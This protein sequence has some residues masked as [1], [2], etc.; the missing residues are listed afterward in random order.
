MDGKNTWKICSFPTFIF[1][2]SSSLV[3]IHAHSFISFA[4]ANPR[5]FREAS[6]LPQD[7]FGNNLPKRLPRIWLTWFL[8]CLFLFFFPRTLLS[9]DVIDAAYNLRI[10]CYAFHLFFF[11]FF[12]FS[13]W[14]IYLS[15][16]NTW[17]SKDAALKGW[18]L[19]FEYVSRVSPKAF[20][21][22]YVRERFCI[23][24]L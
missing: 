5:E 20:M 2:S 15:S 8:Y 6:R 13:P 4:N 9:R 10:G 7:H 22:I 23:H 1:F 11:F 3:E 12:F 19:L 14:C 17:A 24:V 21:N 16:S 18:G